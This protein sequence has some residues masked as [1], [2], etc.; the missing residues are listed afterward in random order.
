[1]VALPRDEDES[2]ASQLSHDPYMLPCVVTVIKIDVLIGRS[3]ITV[4]LSR[5]SKLFECSAS[6]SPPSAPARVG[7]LLAAKL[8]LFSFFGSL[9]HVVEDVARLS[10]DPETAP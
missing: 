7:R 3:R 2:T 10:Q 8:L 5:G 9:A 6:P 1:M 4:A